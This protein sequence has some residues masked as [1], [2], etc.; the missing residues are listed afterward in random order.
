MTT[1]QVAPAT[2]LRENPFEIARTQLRSVGDAFG[3]D[4]NLINVLS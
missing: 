2:H 4:D 3:I 1:L